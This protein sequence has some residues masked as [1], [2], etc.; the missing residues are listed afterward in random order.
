MKQKVVASLGVIKQSG[1][2]EKFRRLAEHLIHRLEQ[3]GLPPIDK[4]T[5]KNLMHQ[6]TVYDG[7]SAVVD[8]LMQLSGF[9]S[10]LKKAQGKKTFDVTGIITL[11]LAQRFHA[12]GSKLRA[13]ERQMEYGSEGFDLQHFYRSMDALLPLAEEFQKRAFETAQSLA[14]E[15]ADCFFFDVRRGLLLRLTSKPLKQRQHGMDFTGLQS[16]TKPTSL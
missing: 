14:P 6:C 1:D 10:I 5:L 7:F 15:P 3:E 13:Y 4:V 8:R 11:L 2:L 12:P 9:R 16:Q